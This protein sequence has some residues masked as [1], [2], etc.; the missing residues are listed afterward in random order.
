MTAFPGF[1]PFERRISE[2]FEEITDARRPDYLDD[3][4]QLTARTSQRPR[5]TFPERWFPVDTTLRRPTLF[6]RLPVRPL[7]LIVVLMTLVAATLA[8]Y[9]GQQRHLPNPYGPAGNGAIVYSSGGDLY[10]RDTLTGQSRLLVGGPGV[11]DYPG[12]TPDGTHLSYVSTHDRADHLIVAN[13]DGTNPV[14]IAV[15]PDAANTY[16]AVSPDGKTFALVYDI[17][18]I[19]TL[20]MAAT[21]GKSSRVIDLGQKRPLDVSWSPPDGNLLLIRVQDQTGSE[22]DLYTLKPDGT[23]L[24]AFNL[25]GTSDFGP[26]YTLSGAQWAPDGKTIA[27]NGTDVAKDAAGVP[28]LQHFR[29]HLVS[30]DGSNDRAIPGPQDPWVHEN[31][32]V[33][34]PDGRWIVVQRWS[35]DRPGGGLA[36]LP[37][38][39]SQPAHEIGPQTVGGNLSK[40]WAPD[41]SRLLMAVNDGTDVFSIDPVTGA[42]EHLDWVTTIP[43][44]QRVALP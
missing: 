40:A 18:G 32:P 35:S 42:Y 39:G 15:L 8:F 1:D 20:S 41:S 29:L 27:Y 38:D 37:A 31:W 11:E 7:I 22:V 5:W 3:I 43:D 23:G 44:W 34:S 14:E 13:A 21:D 36:I 10:V 16:G 24:H 17:R 33:Y 19:P 25:P 12:Y 30:P 9:V 28:I 26:A 4:L 6:G 2:A